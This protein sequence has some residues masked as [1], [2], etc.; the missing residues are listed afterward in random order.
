MRAAIIW[1]IN[2]F[3]AYAMLSGWS[4]KGKFACPHCT[5]DTMSTRLKNGHKECYLG[6][7]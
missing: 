6:H 4:T 1:T 5:Y 3:L 2:D 7:C